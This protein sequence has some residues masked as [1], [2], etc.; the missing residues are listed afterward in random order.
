MNN[1]KRI[2]EQYNKAN[3]FGDFMNMKFD[4]ISP[5]EIEYHIQVKQDFLA[6]PTAMHGGAIASF[7]DAIIGVAALSAVAEENKVVSTI[8]F[9]INFLKPAFLEEHLKGIGKVLQKGN[10]IVVTEGK[11]LNEKG[12]IIAIAQGTL[13]A[14]P[15]EKSDF[16]A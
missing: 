15:I 8:E 14:Y 6:T 1:L 13:N 9:K 16:Y 3:S 10:R 2:I 11:I 7:M 4:I 5:G 12:E